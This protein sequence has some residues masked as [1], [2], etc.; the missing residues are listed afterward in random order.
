MRRPP[1]LYPT[2]ALIAGILL[3]NSLS[4]IYQLEYS[5]LILCIILGIVYWNLTARI[6]PDKLKL[7][8]TRNYYLLI[9]AFICIGVSVSQLH[10]KK[11]QYLPELCKDCESVIRITDLP[12]VYLNGKASINAELIANFHDTSIT[13]YGIKLKL[14]TDQQTAEKLKY[15]DLIQT[16]TPVKPII[17]KSLPGQFDQAKYARNR[18][19]RYS[20]NISEADYE[21][22][23]N[24]AN[25][26]YSV[27][28][29]SKLAVNKF[30]DEL[31]INSNYSAI[32]KALITGDDSGIDAET[33]G[34]FA[35][36]GTVHVLSVS[37]FHLGV[38]LILL[39]FMFR[40]LT[41]LQWLKSLLIISILWAFAL[42]TGA[43]APIV[44]AA[45]MF[46]IIELARVFDKPTQGLNSLCLAAL[47]ILLID[48]TQL[49]DLGFQLSFTALGG[50]L[51]WTKPI[52]KYWPTHNSVGIWIRDL[53]AAGIAAQ[54]ATLPISLYYFHQFPWLFIPANMLVIPLS[55]LL[56]ILLPVTLALSSWVQ[57]V[58]VPIGLLIKIII[59]P[60][61]YLASA[62]WSVWQGIYLSGVECVLLGV[63]I[64]FL[65]MSGR[66]RRVAYWQISYT[67]LAVMF[68]VHTFLMIDSARTIKISYQN[69]FENKLII[70]NTSKK[71]LV[72][73][74]KPID[75][76]TLTRY[77]LP[78]ANSQYLR[79]KQVE[80]SII[81]A[82]NYKIGK[83][84]EIIKI[85]TATYNGFVCL[86][87]DTLRGT[88]VAQK[89][90]L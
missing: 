74:T 7:T 20:I 90:H 8:W 30:I 21:L 77:I 51:V 44:R 60:L 62:T 78:Y 52:S 81:A 65:F 9:I 48:N 39:Q 53:S 18:N 59:I 5:L 35:N 55:S 31:A 25:K 69:T 3:G 14:Y 87:A 15:G 43:A 36:T 45:I 54:L 40:G 70:V 73:G 82:G 2:L 56:L 4:P 89:L 26:F 42:F 58:L 12:N 38:I 71:M 10:N 76:A 61:T 33:Y 63:F 46:S 34:V 24:Q 41:G 22:I 86:N 37:G 83:S 32:I 80:L 47:L 64:V 57:I 6:A 72:Y 23:G 27:F 28:I 11:S 29:Q 79:V 16:Q 88:L 68:I 50:I 84:N 49:F 67:A 85:N 13:R 17:S 1:L 75:S 19:I 66:I